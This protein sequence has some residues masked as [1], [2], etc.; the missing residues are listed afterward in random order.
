[1]FKLKFPRFHEYAYPDF[2]LS[3]IA[4][5]CTLR[6]E[7]ITI[8]ILGNRVASCAHIHTLDATMTVKQYPTNLSTTSTL[9]TEENCRCGEV[10]V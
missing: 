6:A 5:C 4:V 10:G 7:E 8:A 2:N 3:E 1:M 9:G